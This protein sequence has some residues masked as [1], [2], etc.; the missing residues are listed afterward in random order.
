MDI[1]NIITVVS[2][3]FGITVSCLSAAIEEVIEVVPIPKSSKRS[4]VQDEFY[5]YEW[6]LLGTKKWQLDSLVLFDGWDGVGCCI[7]YM[8]R[9]PYSHIGAAFRSEEGEML[10]MESTSQGAKQILSG[11][12]PQVQIN[13]AEDIVMGYNGRVVSR[14]IIFEEG[15]EPDTAEVLEYIKCMLGTSYEKS[16]DHLLRAPW[17]GNKGDYTFKDENSM[18]CSELVA[19]MLQYLGYL[20]KTI[21]PDNY[22]PGHFSERMQSV[23]LTGGASLAPEFELSAPK[24][25]KSCC[26]C[27]TIL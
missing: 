26:S 4:S 25:K 20:D 12:L 15:C 19:H 6:G 2:F 8:S 3:L 5:K 11:I 14:K 1:K 10:L 16:F 27:C 21:T 22:T 7:K 18:F 17:R 9:A 24:G 13:K 23:E